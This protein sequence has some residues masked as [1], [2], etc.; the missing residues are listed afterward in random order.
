MLPKQ[1][2]H[3]QVIRI[4]R[5]FQ[6]GLD[7]MNKDNTEVQHQIIKKLGSEEGLHMIRALTDGL[8]YEAGLDQ[9]LYQFKKQTLPLL[10]TISH[11]NVRS[12]LVLETPVSMICAFVYGPNGRRAISLFTW[13]KTIIASLIGGTSTNDENL[14]VT[15]VTAFL[16]VF[17]MVVDL[18]QT[19][20]IQP[21]LLDILETF[22]PTVPEPV[23]Q[24]SSRALRR[25]RQR[26]GVGENIPAL[27]SSSKETT[28]PAA[29]FDVDQDLPGDLSKLGRRHDNDHSDIAYIQIL[30]TSEEIQSSRSEYLPL[31]DP[32]K[33]HLPGL[34]GLLDRQFR[35]LREDTIGQLRDAV[36]METRRLSRSSST[37]LPE[38]EQ[39]NDLR[40]ILHKNVIIVRPIFDKIKGLMYL[41]ELDQPPAL[42]Q[43]REVERRDWWKNSKQL[44]TDA[45]VCL[46]TSVGQ[47]LFFSVCDSTPA[48]PRTISDSE[49]NERQ[50]ERFKKA[51]G[52]LPSLSKDP[53]RATLT[54]S[55]ADQTRENVTWINNHLGK[56]HWLRQ[57]L[58]EFPGILLP[59]FLPTLKALQEMGRNLDVPFSHFLAP[60]HSSMK[61]LDIPLPD[62]AD[63]PDFSFSLSPVTGGEPFSYSP[64]HPFD[65]ALLR[66][67][68]KLDEAQQ[69]SLLN[70]LASSLA[71][72]QGPPGTGKSYTGVA[73][74]NVLL[75][76]R[77]AANLGPIIC[78]CYTNHALDQLLEHL[79]Q[80]GVEQVVRMGS[81]SKSAMLQ[82]LNLHQVSSKFSNTKNEKYE[83]AQ[84]YTEREAYCETIDALLPR[85]GDLGSVENIRDYLE[86][87]HPSHHSQLFEQNHDQDGFQV[88][89]NRRF[90][91]LKSWM[92]GASA[93]THS[94]RPING[95]LESSLLTMS[96]SERLEL[97]KYWVKE[98]SKS[99]N[100]RFWSTLQAYS[101]TQ[102]AISRYHRERQIRCLLEAHVV[103]VTTTGL[104]RNMDVL[105]RI[106]AKVMVCEEAGEVLEAQTL[107]ALLP[108]V[109][110]AIL[111]GDH[112]QLRPQINNYE[113]Q[114]TNPS[115]EK[116]SLD[117]SLFERLVQ[118]KSGGWRLPHSSLEIQRRMHPS[119]AEL[120]R[121]N[122]YP[123][124]Q[125][126]HSV[127]TYPEVAGM[128]KRLFWLDHNNLEDPSDTRQTHSFSKTNSW[129]VEMTAALV[130]HFVRQGT[131]SSED[132][133]VLTPYLGQLQKLNKR[134]QSSF[135]ILV[136]DRD[137]DDMAAKGL[138]FSDREGSGER[139][140][141]VQKSTLRQALRLAT[142][143]NFQGEEAKVVII[144]LVR[145]NIE[146]K[147]G[148]LKTSNRINVLLSRAQHGMYII[149][150]I[151][152]ARPVPMWDMVIEILDKGQN[153]GK[154]LP[155]CCPRHP[156]TSIEVSAP[157]DFSVFAPEGGCEKKCIL[158][159]PC[160]HACINRCHSD[161]CHMA[162]RCLERCQR[163]KKGCDHA[164]PKVCG[165]KCDEKCQAPVPNVELPCGHIQT[166]ACHV[167]QVPEKAPCETRVNGIVPGC[168]HTVQV[169]CSE[170]PLEPGYK[171]RAV[172]GARLG[173]GHE[174]KRACKNCKQVDA[175]G[176]AFTAHQDCRTLCGRKYT[177]CSHSC[178][179]KCHAGKDCPPCPKPCEVACSHSRCSKKC[180]E[181]C[182]PCVEDCDWSCPH[183]GSCN[184]PCAV[185]CDR[186][187]CSERCSKT[188][189]C[190]H[191]CPTICG[192]V[193]PDPKYCQLC[194]DESVKAMMVDYILS[195]TYSEVNLNESPCI[196]PTC[197]HILT[198]ESMD[199]HM[200]MQKHY[201]LHKDNKDQISIIGLK[202]ASVP[203]E[204]SDLKNCP[205]CRTPLRYINRYGR[206]VRRAWIDEATKKFILWAN[207]KF[208]PLAS[209]L[210]Q[211]EANVLRSEL[212]DP[213]IPASVHNIT[214]LSSA[215]AGLTLE[216][217]QL[218]GSRDQQISTLVKTCKASGRYRA[219]YILRG[220]IK[221]FL[222]AVSEAE[223][224]ISRIFSLVEDARRHRGVS[225]KIGDIP[226]VLQVRNRLLAT[227]LLFRCDY[228]ILSDFASRSEK[229]G[230]ALFPQS[231]TFDLN[232]ARKDCETLIEDSVIRT[233][234]A[235]EVEAHLYWARFAALERRHPA[236]QA[237]S[238]NL[239]D[240][241]LVHVHDAERICENNPGTAGHLSTEAAQVTQMLLSAAPFYAPVTNAEKQAVYA[242]MARDFRGTGHWYYCVN[243]HPFTVGECGLPMEEA[244]CP[245][246]GSPVGGTGHQ[247]AEGVRR[248]E[249]WDGMAQA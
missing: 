186:L 219:V 114:H 196:I 244:R 98:S 47:A 73:I 61:N 175:D 14:A 29:E 159:L 214:G 116:Y 89:R 200:D 110:H 229:S 64:R 218:A 63:K 1:P 92:R 20:Q 141:M 78:V 84:L 22:C 142:V 149:G 28:I 101:E 211:I 227:V 42:A 53:K 237:A 183:Q 246:C 236:T 143:D 72:I 68:S 204:A 157:D 15:A 184:L 234:P 213:K 163:T 171:C 144:S 52:H 25:I 2:I 107:T 7:L 249:D 97:H 82:N 247:P 156:A 99:L 191:Q 108:S 145:C 9:R 209:K 94:R 117:V 58:V 13:I 128:R 199:G 79:I 38:R 54:L 216:T 238:S 48:Q 172:C 207:N 181:P 93:E 27:Q 189:S 188:L 206:V 202:A 139:S 32:T 176:H 23:L 241:A 166:V 66:E 83:L 62:Y 88:V 90:N 225:T 192:E 150:N 71:L 158:R 148:F 226:S 11:S 193:C 228:V 65:H 123:S 182:N 205:I 221:R 104:A 6:A 174:C 57:S 240:Q 223:Q 147:C 233:D 10:Q 67:K 85:L 170:L 197:G 242:A 56:C 30:P 201:H 220:E 155:L 179:E 230:N 173:C 132:I 103:G 140:A 75:Q 118:P 100:R 137:Q 39:R 81:R 80:S 190:G 121:K 3:Q 106:Q 136:G 74:I 135:E 113:F 40:Y 115:G 243:G 178:E 46:A 111:I 105:R 162:V 177:T 125:D 109:E 165:D 146:H 180:H 95:L 50:Q 161:A 26:L 160:G 152:T 49:E 37:D 86:N 217:L 222:R 224:P 187:P 208:L 195:S 69:L 124:L 19:A 185:P 33:H 168:K 35:L 5:F 8:T 248:A 96:E 70:A 210:D 127:T 119:I 18:N 36:Y 76:S 129:E 232:D 51:L 31:N 169:R 198:L 134:L 17:E 77:S 120:V 21:E 194:G 151:D 131:Y 87:H 245:Q 164:C 138:K 112:E 203:F 130:T 4:G 91:P 34:A 153:I 239:H 126:H 212:E 45:F 60:D 215:L 167:A 59:S 122:L 43:K 133:A 44:Q 235:Q 231:F 12:S 24:G 55:L 102:D 41:A 16:A 154:A